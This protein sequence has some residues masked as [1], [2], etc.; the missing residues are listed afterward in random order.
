MIPCCMPNGSDQ[1]LATLYFPLGPILSRFRCIALL[2]PGSFGPHS[3][4]ILD[5]PVHRRLEDG[6]I[7]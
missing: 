6:V 1:R 4:F 7:F 2:C 3:H 5:F